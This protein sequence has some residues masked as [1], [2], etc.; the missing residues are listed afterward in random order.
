MGVRA[1]L[2]ASPAILGC[3]PPPPLPANEFDEVVIEGNA[4]LSI[5]DGRMGIADKV[6]G[7]HLGDEEFK[8]QCSGR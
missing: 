6:R 2:P 5:E 7:D 3:V 1:L 4:S 8:G